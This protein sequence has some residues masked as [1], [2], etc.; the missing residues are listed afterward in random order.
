MLDHEGGQLV[1]VDEG[2][3]LGDAFFD[4]VV[5]FSRKSARR[6]KQAFACALPDEGAEEFLDFR[7]SDGAVGA[8]FFAWM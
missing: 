5:G 1:A 8:H 4:E 6:Y 3:A 7:A 2:D